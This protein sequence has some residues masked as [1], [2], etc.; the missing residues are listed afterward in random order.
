MVLVLPVVAAAVLRQ[1]VQ[2]APS[3]QA[4]MEEMAPHRPFLAVALLTLVVAAVVAAQDKPAV[5]VAA[6]LVETALVVN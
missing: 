1:R 4:V 3:T 6:A 2:M 5:L